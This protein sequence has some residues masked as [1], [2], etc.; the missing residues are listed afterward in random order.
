LSLAVA[1]R[2]KRD[3]SGRT[4]DTADIRVKQIETDEQLLHHQ[5]TFSLE[6]PPEGLEDREDALANFA[7]PLLGVLPNVG[8][9][10][11]EIDLNNGHASVSGVLYA[12]PLKD[13][14]AA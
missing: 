3:E 14:P 13:R 11:W 9:Y 5:V 2:V 8:A 1:I 6:L 7:V 10:R 12:S 4:D